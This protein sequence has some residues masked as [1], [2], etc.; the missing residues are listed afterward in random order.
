MRTFKFLI[1]GALILVANG[2]YAQRDMILTQAGEEV[3]CRIIDETPVRFVF[4]YLKD[5][6][7][8]RSEIFKNLVTSFKFNFYDKDL[9]NA[10][11]LPEAMYRATDGVDSQ[12]PRSLSTSSKSTVSKRKKKKKKSKSEAEKV[13]TDSDPLKEKD[14]NT[15]EKTEVVS[16]SPSTNQT[17]AQSNKR[18]ERKNRKTESTTVASQPEQVRSGEIASTSSRQTEKK[19]KSPVNTT[20]KNETTEKRESVNVA[21]GEGEN[22][23]VKKCGS[24]KNTYRK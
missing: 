9:P 3:R 17:S 8:Y 14:T 15:L 1:V 22:I 12:S 24:E 16:T 6:K 11:K 5:G 7:P 13:A 4:A 23:E 10:D 2:A 18:I 20:K 21:A 19:P